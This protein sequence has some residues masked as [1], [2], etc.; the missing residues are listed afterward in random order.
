MNVNFVYASIFLQD[1]DWMN[2]MARV[3]RRALSSRPKTSITSKMEGDVVPPQ[4]ATRT[5]GPSWP[6]L[7]P[8]SSQIP[9]NSASIA[10]VGEI[11]EL[12]EALPDLFEQG[13]HVRLQEFFRGLGVIVESSPGNRKPPRRPSPAWSWPAPGES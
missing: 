1:R 8:R 5:G 4:R 7:I 6:S 11:G 3:I 10:L 2:S 13:D 12:P 9:L